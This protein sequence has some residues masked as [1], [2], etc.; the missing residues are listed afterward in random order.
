[1]PIQEVPGAPPGPAEPDQA[2]AKFF[3]ELDEHAT[4]SFVVFTRKEAKRLYDILNS[5]VQKKVG[6]SEVSE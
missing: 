1:M 5:P 3:A 6:G 2:F 4:R